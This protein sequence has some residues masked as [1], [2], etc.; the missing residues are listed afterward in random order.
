MEQSGINIEIS[1]QGKFNN[2]AV[3][4]PVLSSNGDEN[5]TPVISGSKLKAASLNIENISQTG[6]TFSGK[7][8][9][10]RSGI[11]NIYTLPMKDGKVKLRFFTGKQ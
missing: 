10:N 7:Q 4:L 11:Y 6:F 3:T 9:S 2:A 5:F 1:L 8:L